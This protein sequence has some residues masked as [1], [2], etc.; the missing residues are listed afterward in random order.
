MG[1]E[2]FFYLHACLVYKVSVVLCGNAGGRQRGSVFPLSFC[3]M[4]LIN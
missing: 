1:K 2:N 3:L 4:L